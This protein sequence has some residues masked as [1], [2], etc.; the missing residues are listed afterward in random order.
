MTEIDRCTVAARNAHKGF[1][2]FTSLSI[3]FA[4]AFALLALAIMLIG[5]F[6]GRADA[7]IFAEAFLV[8]IIAT[9]VLWLVWHFFQY[10]VGVP[11]TLLPIGHPGNKRIDDFIAILNRESGPRAYYYSALLRHRVPLNRRVFFSRFRYLL[12]SEHLADRKRVT[13]FPVA[14]PVPAEIFLDS[15]DVALLVAASKPKRKGGPG[16]D[17]KCPYLDAV[18]DLIGDPAILSLDLSNEAA[19]LQKV[20]TMMLAWFEG[21]ADPSA[22]APRRA[23][24]APYAAKVI[25]RLKKIRG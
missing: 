10:G 4:F 24:V 8:T 12:F 13:R 19:A 2:T 20:E 21:N 16:R 22:D 7:V 18:I 23:G 11:D 6:I 3:R 9:L 25:V 5:V 14:M 15:A 1:V 17:P